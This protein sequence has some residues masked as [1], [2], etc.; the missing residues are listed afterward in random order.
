MNPRRSSS[1]RKKGAE[2]ENY[3]YTKCIETT[4]MFFKYCGF[5]I[6]FFKEKPSSST[7]STKHLKLF[8]PLLST[9]PAAK[10]RWFSPQSPHRQGG[11]DSSGVSATENRAENSPPPF[12]ITM[13]CFFVVRCTRYCHRC[14]PWFD[15]NVLGTCAHVEWYATDGVRWL[16]WGGVGREGEDANVNIPWTCEAVLF[17]ETLQSAYRECIRG[18]EWAKK[19]KMNVCTKFAGTQE[20]DCTWMWLK[21]HV[22]TCLKNT[23]FDTINK[24]LEDY[25]DRFVHGYNK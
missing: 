13:T 24:R 8:D 12:E 7:K 3:M 23:S 11:N 16:G 25:I 15:V 18:A 1:C 17:S 2:N 10:V 19:V 9:A 5:W 4:Y 22:P 20:L 6:F 14:A 21:R